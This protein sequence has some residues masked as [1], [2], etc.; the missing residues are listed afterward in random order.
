MK[1]ENFRKNLFF[2]IFTKKAMKLEI[3]EKKHRQTENEMKFSIKIH[4]IR[5]FP[6]KI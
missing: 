6:Q 5:N 1:T 4:S 2:F 3:R